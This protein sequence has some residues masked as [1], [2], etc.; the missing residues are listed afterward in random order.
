MPRLASASHTPNDTKHD[1][2]ARMS[3]VAL[4][5]K[6]NADAQAAFRARRANYISTLE[7]T[8]VSYFFLN[9]SRFLTVRQS[10]TSS[11]SCC[12]FRI[13]AVKPVQRPRSYDKIMPAYD[14]LFANARISGEL[15]GLANRATVPT[16]MTRRRRRRCLTHILLSIV[17]WDL[18]SCRIT[19]QTTCRTVP[20][21]ILRCVGVSTLHRI[22]RPLPM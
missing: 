16:L 2:S 14:T 12:S 1:I 3:D 17:I 15:C 20:V 10:P 5:K 7:E 8:G 22:H 6:K 11:R 18:R 9:F 19:A 13:H 21:T 4:R